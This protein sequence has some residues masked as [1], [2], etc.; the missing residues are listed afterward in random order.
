MN[1]SMPHN[2]DKDFLILAI[3]AGAY[4]DRRSMEALAAAST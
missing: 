4:P 2:K 1:V 3:C